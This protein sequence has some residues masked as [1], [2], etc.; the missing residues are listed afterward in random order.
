VRGVRQGGGAESLDV[1]ISIEP[2]P[3]EAA[4]VN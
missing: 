3:A 2:L 1:S 4:R